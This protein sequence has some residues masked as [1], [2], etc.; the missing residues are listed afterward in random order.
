M[1]LGNSIRKIREIKGF[2][3]QYVASK[4]HISQRQLS[5]IEN[6]E[7]DI[8]FSHIQRLCNAL[9][10]SVTQLLNFNENVFFQNKQAPS[11]SVKNNELLPVKL[12][13][14]YESRISHLEKEVVFLQNLLKEKKG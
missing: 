4:L 9:E 6:N 10:V 14:Q 1:N 7:T 5:R 3:Q 12:I 8:K 11:E 2:S 13:E